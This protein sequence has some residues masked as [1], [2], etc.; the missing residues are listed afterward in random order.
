MNNNA[1]KWVKVL[2]SGK[3]KQITGH[4]K[5][6]EGYCCLGVACDLYGKEKGI[7]WR[8]NLFLS[9]EGLLPDKVKK[10]LGLKTRDGEYKGADLTEKND[11]G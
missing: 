9:Q 8:K 11:R 10:W 7:K 6:D 3:Y 4:L 1:K 2:I 5:T